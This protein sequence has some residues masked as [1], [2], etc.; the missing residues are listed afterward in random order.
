[1][2]TEVHSRDLLRF[3]TSLLITFG[4]TMR[5]NIFIRFSTILGGLLML[6]V[7]VIP[8]AVQAAVTW[9]ATVGA[10]SKDMGNQAMAFLPNE[11]WI[12][13][14]DSITWSF[15]TNEDHT[16]TFLA[17]GQSRPLNFNTGCPGAQAS[18]SSYPATPCVNSGVL[19]NGAT[20]S[21]K[22]PTAGNYKFVCLI[23]ASMTG[24]VHV[25][26]T[27]PLPHS[28]GFYDDE[29]A[30]EARAIISDADH[31][32]DDQGKRHS[33][34]SN[35]VVTTGEIVAT[36]GGSQYL[37]IMRFL[38]GTTMIHVGDTVE[39]TNLD[40]A[41]PHTV[42]FFNEPMGPPQSPA[43]SPACAVTT[44]ADGA[45]HATI[46]STSASQVVHSGFIAAPRQDANGFPPA[47]PGVT[48]FRVTFTVPGTF[49]YICAIHDELGMK[50]KV[51]VLP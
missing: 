3:P 35:K 28:Q 25:Q 45:R 33:K 31:V 34:E 7:L 21:V 49:N 29:A 44:D 51:I 43:C 1:L 50:A 14:N 40:P 11:L 30:D 26:D 18:G 23:H 46:S 22:F 12:Y 38:E 9:N 13:I 8:R 36:G 42:T 2:L 19:A 4:G 15:P 32:T 27:L 48:R 17:P 6:A 47:D 5:K 37:A 24:V 39:W 10:Q 20:Y 41:E 16:V